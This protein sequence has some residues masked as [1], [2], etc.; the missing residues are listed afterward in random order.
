MKARHIRRL[1]KEVSKFEEYIVIPC[2][3]MFGEFSSLTDEKTDLHY[4]KAE[5][6]VRAIRKYQRW[7]FRKNKEHHK[8]AF[9]AP[10]CET[11]RT[12]GKFKVVDRKG[13]ARYYN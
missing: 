10:F 3:G 8:Y 7:Y 5:N 13:Y 6:P 2:I 4:F 11:S 9:H 1:R 12:W